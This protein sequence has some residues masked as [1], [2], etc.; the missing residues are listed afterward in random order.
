VGAFVA[1]TIK[2]A[3][4]HLLLLLLPPPPP[5]VV[6]VVVRNILMW[7]PWEAG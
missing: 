3:Q 7:S 1:T 4:D 5:V 6:V 2:R